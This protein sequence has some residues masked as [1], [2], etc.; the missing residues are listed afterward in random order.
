MAFTKKAFIFFS[1][2]SISSLLSSCSKNKHFSNDFKGGQF[3]AKVYD[4]DNF[5]EAE[6]GEEEGMPKIH[7]TENTISWSG[8]GKCMYKYFDYTYTGKAEIKNDAICI[9]FNLSYDT[10]P[11]YIGKETEITECVC[12]HDIKF[13]FTEKVPLNLPI[14]F[15]E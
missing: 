4:C 15:V 1:I 12:N 10:K 5:F 3:K 9:S 14:K 8:Y 2:L 13:T 11:E 6:K 7:R